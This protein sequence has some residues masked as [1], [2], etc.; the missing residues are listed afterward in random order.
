M[1]IAVL[2]ATGATGRLLVQQA[3]SRGH[4][5]LALARDPARID[6]SAARTSLP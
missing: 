2:A 5:V 3:L 6:T 4:T 1:R